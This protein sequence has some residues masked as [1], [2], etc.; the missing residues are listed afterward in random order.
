MYSSGSGS[1]VVLCVH[2]GGYTGLT[3]SLTAPSLKHAYRVIAPDLRGHGESV[4]AD[5]ADL[6]ARTLA[7]DVV[8]IAQEA[9]RPAEEGQE[10]LPLVLV[11]PFVVTPLQPTAWHSLCDP[12]R[13]GWNEAQ[14]FE[15]FNTS[16]HAASSNQPVHR[17]HVP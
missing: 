2:G 14:S 5:D 11:G 3:W 9:C 10:P 7:A 13:G 6:S 17:V 4:T 12:P 16:Y 8:A 15:L 1:A